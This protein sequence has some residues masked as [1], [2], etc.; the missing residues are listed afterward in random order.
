MTTRAING[1]AVRELRDALGLSQRDL[2]AR[3]DITQGALSNIETGKFAASP[4]MARKLADGMG[5][6]L[7]AITYPVPEPEP[8]TS[9]PEVVTA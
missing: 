9:P 5:V 2:A 6:S 7:A 8:V 3:C 4:V 1:A